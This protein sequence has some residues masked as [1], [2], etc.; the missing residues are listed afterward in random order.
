MAFHG[1]CPRCGFN[2][3]KNNS[4]P[5]NE[6]KSLYGQRSNAAKKA[7]AVASK[8]IYK[9]IPTDA[10]TASKLA[11]M[12]KIS[13]V[14]DPELIRGCQAYSNSIHWQQGKGWHYLAAIINNVGKNSS[15]MAYSEKKRIGTGPPK[16][17]I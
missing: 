11:F 7:I 2:T 13:A 17:E 10:S 4:N 15:A 9:H 14:G 6:L 1:T 5:A 3:Y 12:Y 8:L 16:K